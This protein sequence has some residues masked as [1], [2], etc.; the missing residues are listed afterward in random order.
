MIENE[1]IGSTS[2]SPQSEALH[3][4]FGALDVVG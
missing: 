3:T 2:L 4:I 1:R